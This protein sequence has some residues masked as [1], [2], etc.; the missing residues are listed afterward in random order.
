MDKKRPIHETKEICV[1]ELK[2]AYEK[3]TGKRADGQKLREFET[4][5]EKEILPKVYEQK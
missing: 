4:K 3:N 1:K 2:D 5:Y